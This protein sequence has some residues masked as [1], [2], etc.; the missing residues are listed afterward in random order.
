MRRISRASPPHRTVRVRRDGRGCQRT[1]ARRVEEGREVGPDGRESIGDRDAQ[2]GAEGA[3]APTRP[4]VGTCLPLV[5]RAGSAL[6]PDPRVG[7]EGHLVGEELTVPG[8]VPL[9]DER[10]VAGHPALGGTA[11]E[12]IG[13]RGG[14]ELDEIEMRDGDATGDQCT[15]QGPLEQAVL[16]SEGV[17]GRE[18]PRQHAYRPSSRSASV[19]TDSS[20]PTTSRRTLRVAFPDPFAPG[21][22]PMALWARLISFRSTAASAMTMG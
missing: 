7:P 10:G 12:A 13:T 3:T 4:V 17:D 21:R 20:S 6:P 22:L 1:V 11:S 5:V 9:G 2:T 19:S 15:R 8:G 14:P 18:I 16:S